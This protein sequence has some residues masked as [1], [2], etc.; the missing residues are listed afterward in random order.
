MPAF[1]YKNIG[2]R[3]TLIRRSLGLSP[4]DFAKSLDF[5]VVSIAALENYELFGIWHDGHRVRSFP[6][7]EDHIQ[8]IASKYHISEKWIWTGEGKVPFDQ[9]PSRLQNALLICLPIGIEQKILFSQIHQ[10]DDILETQTISNELVVD[11]YVQILKSMLDIG[12][13]LKSNSEPNQGLP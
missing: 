1:D 11:A 4:F 2:R 3:I 6:N 7:Y 5:S 9:E 13:I 10:I 12:L 8:K